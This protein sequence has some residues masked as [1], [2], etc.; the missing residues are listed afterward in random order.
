MKKLILISL[1][2]AVAAG[3]FAKKPVNKLVPQKLPKNIEFS[4]GFHAFCKDLAME[5]Q[6]LKSL[7]EYMPSN[8]MQSQYAFT[9]MP[10]GKT[11]IEGFIQINPAFFD[12]YNFEQLGGYLIYVS[13]GLYSYKMPVE[14]IFKMLKIKGLVQVDIPEKR[15]KK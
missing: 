7:S 10:D 15:I 6:G 5:S 12:A 11:G 8:Q 1:M 3:S 2:V 9:T 14:V 13:E 4:T